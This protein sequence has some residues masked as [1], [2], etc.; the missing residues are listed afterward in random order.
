M[1]NT[2]DMW[3]DIRSP[4][5]SVD[6]PSPNFAISPSTYVTFMSLSFGTDANCCN[7]LNYFEP[8]LS[9]GEVQ[10]VNTTTAKQNI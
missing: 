1:W 7:G 8:S 4:R 10:N 6:N 5:Y 2:R 3:L 9:Q